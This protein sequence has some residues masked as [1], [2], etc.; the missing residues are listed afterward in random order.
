MG[1]EEAQKKAE[2]P[3]D[4]LEQH[5]YIPKPRDPDTGDAYTP[6]PIRFKDHQRRIINEALSRL[7]S[8]L[9]RYSTIVYSAPKKSGKS[10]LSSGVALWLAQEYDYS[11]VYCLANDGKQSNDRLFGPIYN[12]LKLHQRL[13]GILKD[14][15][16]NLTETMLPNLGKI[17]SIP[18]DAA[19]EAGAEPTGTFWSELWGFDTEAKRR[20]W[21][22]MTIPP[23]EYGHAIRWV[24][25]Y[26]GFQ[27]QSDLLWQI[28]EEAVIRGVPHPDFLDLSSE[29]KPVVYVNEGAGLFCYWDHEPRMPWQSPEYYAR[30]ARLLHPTE[31]E[32]IHRNHWVSAIG[33]FV[34]GE[35]WQGCGDTKIK[36]LEN[37]KV[38]VVVAVDAATENDCAAIIAVTRNAG[39]P[40]TDV[41]I[42]AC[43]IFRPAGNRS[44]IILSDTIGRTIMEWGMRWNIVCI[45]YDA[46]QME[47]L[48]QDYRRGQV[49]VDPDKVIGMS[50]EE[51]HDYL[52]PIKAA[53]QRWYYK[54]SQNSQRAVADKQLYDMI[55]NQQIHWNPDDR[56]WD[57]GERGDVETLTKHIKQAGATKGKGQYRIVKLSNTMKIDGVV[58]LAMAAHRCLT[59]NITNNEN[60]LLEEMVPIPSKE[61]LEE[62]L[63]ILRIND[64]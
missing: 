53:I 12:C 11:R 47:K 40:E 51:L 18:C 57:I 43:K 3:S 20:L 49:N 7:P 39:K 45:A 19:G 5:F 6:G 32:R 13:G 15:R 64:G 14:V 8:G 28:Y 59:L 23:T 60:N 48:V 4:W 9:F 37:P 50:P 1:T 55:V 52:M 35:W 54:F 31:F 33:S 38:P 36:P 42:R 34:Q 27:G 21:S 17:E 29:G 41:D 10:A 61:V 26:A 63:R 44:T 22:E 58:A 62:R 30:E 46:F 24:E 25:S 56:D 2:L 16:P